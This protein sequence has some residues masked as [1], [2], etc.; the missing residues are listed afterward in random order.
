M[1]LFRP[2]NVVS[3]NV[4]YPK[5]E[6]LD[7]GSNAVLRFQMIGTVQATVSEG[8]D[9]LRQQPFVVDPKT[10]IVKLNFDPQRGM[11]GYFDFKVSPRLM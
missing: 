11:K 5:A 1:V 6:D 7:Y 2:I 9:H 4:R 3:I 10:G 8:L